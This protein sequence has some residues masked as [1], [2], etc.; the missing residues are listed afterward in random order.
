MGKFTCELLRRIESK[1]CSSLNIEV[2]AS[3]I[4]NI[5]HTNCLSSCS[6]PGYIYSR[7]LS[8]MECK[9][10]YNHFKIRPHSAVRMLVCNMALCLRQHTIRKGQS[11]SNLHLMVHIGEQLKPRRVCAYERTNQSLRCSHTQ[12]AK[13]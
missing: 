11:V 13:A 10:M 7:N 12:K 2:N 5:P 1:V 3:N 9:R 8:R 4:S 6:K